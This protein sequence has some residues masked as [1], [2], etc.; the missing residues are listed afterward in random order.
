M[1]KKEIPAIAIIKV[2]KK[3]TLSYQQTKSQTKKGTLRIK[4][5]KK[6]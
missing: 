3:I 6:P 5:W 2:L 4:N 1:I